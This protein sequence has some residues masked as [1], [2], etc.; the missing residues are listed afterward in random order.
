MECNV[1]VI[2]AR[3]VEDIKWMGLRRMG[4]IEMVRMDM[5]EYKRDIQVFVSMRDYINCAY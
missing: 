4:R 3:I 1:N 2:M 5:V